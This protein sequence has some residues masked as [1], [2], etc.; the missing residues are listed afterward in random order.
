MRM[1]DPAYKVKYTLAL[2]HTRM[3]TD[4]ISGGGCSPIDSGITHTVKK[5]RDPK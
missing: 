2:T 1:C 5:T 4:A 3:L